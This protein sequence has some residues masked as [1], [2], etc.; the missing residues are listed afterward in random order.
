MS[1]P[2]DVKPSA[3]RVLRRGFR[4]TPEL[5]AGIGPTIAAALLSSSG[6]LVMPIVG[7]VAID[8]GFTQA[9]DGSI[10]VDL[11]YVATV[12][13]LGVLLLA[14]VYVLDR[15]TLWRLL[16]AGEAALSKLRVRAFSH[17]HE[18]S[19][20]EHSSTRRGLLTARVT[21]DTE[22]L[23]RFIHW[24]GITWILSLIHI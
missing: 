10:D 21:S 2:D 3:L 19:I 24:G 1:S 18:L 8:N 4:E 13:A 6:Q 11:R 16:V 23:A 22:T 12:G 7:Q 14:A 9:T 5:R 17:I 15:I 20:A